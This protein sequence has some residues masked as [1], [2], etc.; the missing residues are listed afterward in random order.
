MNLIIFNFYFQQIINSPLL[1]VF[2]ML[3]VSGN[4]L[5]NVS[6]EFGWNF[7]ASTFD[8]KTVN[9]EM[10]IIVRL[11]VQMVECRTKLITFFLFLY[12]YHS[13]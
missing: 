7:R 9:K 12:F 10:S 5:E 3:D 1:K 6:L 8:R 2:D 13:C 11:I 4:Y